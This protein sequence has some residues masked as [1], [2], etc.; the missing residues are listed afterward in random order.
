MLRHDIKQ[1]FITHSIS[2]CK[3]IIQVIIMVKIKEENNYLTTFF[4]HLLTDLD[5]YLRP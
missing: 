3:S 4:K 5:R 1:L 2:K